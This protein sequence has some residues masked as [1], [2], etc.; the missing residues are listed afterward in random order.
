[1]DSETT[2]PITISDY[3]IYSFGSSGNWVHK[4][5]DLPLNPADGFT[6]KGPG[7]EQNYTFE[8]TPNDG[9]IKTTVSRNTSY[10]VGFTMSIFLTNDFLF[11]AVCHCQKV[12]KY[13]LQSEKSTH[14]LNFQIKSCKL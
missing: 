6:F 10:L 9:L 3:W 13:M 7:Q 14:T 5:S 12:P 11:M 8:G 2:S 1:M 4:G